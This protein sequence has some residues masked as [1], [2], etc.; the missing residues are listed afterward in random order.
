MKKEST[1][2]PSAKKT[3]PTKLIAIG[4]EMD[5]DAPIKDNSKAIAAQIKKGQP[6]K[7][8]ASLGPDYSVDKRRAARREHTN[9]FTNRAPSTS[10]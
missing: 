10:K 5:A 7:N 8:A 2:R 1:P 4:L 6:M 3:A 9:H